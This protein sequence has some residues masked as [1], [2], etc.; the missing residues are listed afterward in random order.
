MGAQREIAKNGSI[1]Q[2]G[3]RSYLEYEGGEGK[4]RVAIE[5]VRSAETINK[6][7]L[8]TLIVGLGLLFVSPP[9]GVAGAILV[10]L[11]IGLILRY[12]A[13]ERRV[14][15]TCEGGE[16]EFRKMHATRKR[17]AFLAQINDALRGGQ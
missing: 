7:A 5:K 16:I 9:L 4:K 13:P 11:G 15:V 6:R 14:L 8:W 2:E 3:G 10:V 12:V 1:V 17:K